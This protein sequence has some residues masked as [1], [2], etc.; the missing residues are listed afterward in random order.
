MPPGGLFTGKTGR[1]STIIPDIDQ[2]V[3]I[4]AG[5]LPSPGEYIVTMDLT[6]PD[7]SPV[8]ELITA[9]RRSKT[10]F[11]AVSLGIFDALARGPRTVAA[12]A[13][14]LKL[15]PGALERLLDACVGLTLLRHNG[16]AYEN[17]PSASAFLTSTS[18]RRLTGYISYSNDAMWTLWGH[19][20]GAIREGTHRWKQAFGLEGNIF[21]H[22]FRTPEAMREFLMGMHGQG[23]LSSPRVVAAFDLSRHRRLIDLGGATGHLALA[24]CQRYSQLRAVVFD[25]PEVVPLTREIVATSGLGDRVEVIAGDF[26]VDDLPEGDV[27]ALGRILHDWSEDKIARL[28]SRIHARLPAEGAILIAEKLLLDDRSGPSWAQMQHLNMLLCTEGRERTLD[29]YAAIL[30]RAGFRE[31]R[32]CRTPSPLDAVLAV[33]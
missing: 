1:I 23:L 11:A 19:L 33:K 22:F 8:L 21:D 24:A 31:V 28:L 17:T 4:V 30:T 10:M 13:S 5:L 20:E 12:L 14:E 6:P 32:G 15:H 25:L 29:G 16:S 26:F 27:V 18:P 7:P 3:F 2:P 9:F